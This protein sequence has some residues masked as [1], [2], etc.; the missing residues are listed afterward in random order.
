MSELKHLANV[1]QKQIRGKGVQALSDSPNVPSRYGISGLS[2]EELKRHFDG[3]GSFLAEKVNE[4]QNTLSSADATQYIA[5]PTGEPANLR[6]FL[7]SFDTGALADTV[8]KLYEGGEK[9][10]LQS[11]INALV[12]SLAE[13]DAKAGNAAERAD[14]AADKAT[15]VLDLLRQTTGLDTERVC[16]KT[17]ASDAPDAETPGT[18]GDLYVCD[19]DFGKTVYVCVRAADGAYEWKEIP[20]LKL[21]KELVTELITESKTW[22]K[23]DLLASDVTVRIFGGGGGGGSGIK[24]NYCMSGGGG[25][26]HMAYD[27]IARKDVPDTVTVT[28][29][30]GGAGGEIVGD[31]GSQSGSP[32]GASSFGTLL[33]ASGGGGG[34]YGT[35]STKYAVGG[36]GGSGGGSGGSESTGGSP[37]PASG[38]YGGDGGYRDHP[39][40]NG[41]DCS[42]LASPFGGDGAGGSTASYGGYGG[43]GGYGGRGGNGGYRESGSTKLG[44]GGGGGGFGPS[45]NG[46]SGGSDFNDGGSGGYAAGGGG[47]GTGYGVQVKPKGGNGGAGIC[48][49]TYYVAKLTV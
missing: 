17:I 15:V 14:A 9:K 13:T 46:G 23:P 36:S 37:N 33:S 31:F 12:T 34:G 2:A 7:E 29:G 21:K 4:L 49:L 42:D 19:G 41:I 27:V 39:A 24:Y 26:G 6:D 35:S 10:S 18:A 16:L 1:T 38:S 32:G 5:M 47:G 48:I 25:G 28:I 40:E 20:F 3:L 44:S 11:V 8:L 45:G 22:Q 30:T 43:G